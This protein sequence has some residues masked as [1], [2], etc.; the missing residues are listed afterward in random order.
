[1]WDISISRVMFSETS[2]IAKIKQLYIDVKKCFKTPLEQW[3][4]SIHK[5][6]KHTQEFTIKMMHKYTARLA[7]TKQYDCKRQAFL[8]SRQLSIQML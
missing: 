7:F 2:T 8:L 3:P 4:D 5:L 1:M 6:F